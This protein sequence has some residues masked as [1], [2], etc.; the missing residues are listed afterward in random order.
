MR[1]NEPVVMLMDTLR[2]C[3]TGLRSN[4]LLTD[5][6]CH[7][8][9]ARVRALNPKALTCLPVEQT[10]FV[11]LDTE[12]TGFKV[13]GG[14]E[15]VSIALLEMRGL[16]PTGREFT[17]L[18][19]PRRAIPPASTAVHNICDADVV[20][21]PVIEEVLHDVTQFI[22]ESVLV[23]HHVPFDLRFLNKALHRGFR[24]RL[25]NPWLDT[26]LM[27][28]ALSGRLAHYSLEDVARF[29]N[30]E[31]RDRHTARG[32]ALMTAEMFKTLASGLTAGHR[33]VATLIKRQTQ[34]GLF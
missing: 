17:T 18:V 5:P 1:A 32:D 34:A 2:A 13:Y 9:H 10:R 8:V 11:V 20:H 33:T 29:C 26:M 16:E 14:D 21:A 28:V 30:V 4:P 3:L 27:Y 15:I 6:L 19:N 24:C 7:A 12:T 22:G 23:G 25:R 31:I